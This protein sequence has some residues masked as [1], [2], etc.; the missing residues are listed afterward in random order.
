MRTLV[1]FL[2]DVII[3][4]ALFI[5]IQACLGVFGTFGDVFSISVWATMSAKDV[6]IL[7]GCL[8]LTLCCI[9]L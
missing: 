7:L 1:L 5:G 8:V 4:I 9:R 6:W 3:A 2:I